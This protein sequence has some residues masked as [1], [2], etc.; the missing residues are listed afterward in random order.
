M[1][2]AHDL[3]PP[4]RATHQQF[5]LQRQADLQ[6]ARLAGADRQ[7]FR[8]AQRLADLSVDNH[9]G[10]NVAIGPPEINPDDNVLACRDRRTRR[11]LTE[12]HDALRIERAVAAQLGQDHLFDGVAFD[13]QPA[14]RRR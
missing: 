7:P 13:V 14:R 1:Q 5:R 8:A 2:F 12:H 6:R 3:D 9:S 4:S 11:G 10:R